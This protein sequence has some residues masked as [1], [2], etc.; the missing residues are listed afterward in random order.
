MVLAPRLLGTSPDAR[1]VIIRVEDAWGNTTT[2]TPNKV[3]LAVVN[4]TDTFVVETRQVTLPQRGW[5]TLRESLVFQEA[6]TYEIQAE[7]VIAAGQVCGS[8]A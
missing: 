7:I 5:S 3:N 2:N 1:D 4:L 8:F 6:G